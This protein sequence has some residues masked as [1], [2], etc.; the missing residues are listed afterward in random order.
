MITFMR[1][2]FVVSLILLHLIF[3]TAF[4]QYDKNL[5][6]TYKVGNPYSIGGKMYYPKEYAHLQEEGFI[7]WYGP[8]FHNKKTSNGAIF[9]KNTYTAAHK[10]LPMPSV[11]ELTNLENG[12]RVILVVN[13]RGPFSESQ[14]RILDVSERIAQEMGFSSAG[15]T[16]GRIK[17]L[18]KETADLKAGR[19]VKLGMI[20]SETPIIDETAKIKYKEK[21]ETNEYKAQIAG[22]TMKTSFDFG[23]LKGSYIQ[24]GAFRSR[25]NAMRVLKSLQAHG[26]EPAKIRTERMQ[27]G[28]NLDLVRVGPIEDEELTHSIL[29]KIQ[30][31][32]YTNAKILILK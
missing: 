4:S 10:T 13:D 29:N 5:Y 24:V 9:N 27:T 7:S 6:G 18:P 30:N 15:V 17:L 32:G 22:G 8:G 3:N 19:Y 2:N 25:E 14:S 23:Y 26:I 11:V 21:T 20:S 31:M 12:K 28:D 16:R 1:S